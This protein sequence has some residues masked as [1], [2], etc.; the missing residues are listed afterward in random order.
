[1]DWSDWMSGDGSILIDTIPKGWKNKFPD[2]YKK[3]KD[4][5]GL[6]NHSI[7]LSR[8]SLVI[9]KLLASNDDIVVAKDSDEVYLAFKEIYESKHGIPC[10]NE[11]DPEAMKNS[12]IKKIEE[13]MSRNNQ[14][15]ATDILNDEV[16]DYFL[17]RMDYIKKLNPQKNPT[18]EYTALQK[19]IKYFVDN[20]EWIP[21]STVD[22]LIWDIKYD[23]LIFE[24][25]DCLIEKK[26][27][28]PETKK[29]FFYKVFKGEKLATFDKVD[30]RII[31]TSTVQ[32]IIE[33]IL[34]LKNAKLISDIGLNPLE[35]GEHK[36]YKIACS[37]FCK[38]DF[39]KNERKNIPKGRGN[40]KLELI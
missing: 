36:I 15:K 22:S 29:D 21:K 34:L 31:W 2:F 6:M 12:I 4:F 5:V 39:H 3:I 1:M 11:R 16:K 24:L 27:I 25:Y 9:N 20:K 17:T 10:V 19:V 18:V 30:K 8:Y 40:N 23:K 33:L 26:Y 14:A 35:R 32:D 37:C 38:Y 7:H 13:A 28:H